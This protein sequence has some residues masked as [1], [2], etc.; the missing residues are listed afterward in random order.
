MVEEVTDEEDGQSATGDILSLYDKDDSDSLFLAGEEVVASTV[1]Q[2][3]GVNPHN[4]QPPP[5]LLL[6]FQSLPP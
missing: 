4:N 5:L 6:G 1:V 2:H 3:R